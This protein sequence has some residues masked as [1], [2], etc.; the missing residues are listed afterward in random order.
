[1][2][3][4]VFI[5]TILT[6]YSCK[7]VSQTSNLDSILNEYDRKYRI[8]LNESDYTLIKKLIV[9]TEQNCVNF[10]TEITSKKYSNSFIAEFT[11]SMVSNT[12]CLKEVMDNID[13]YSAHG[14]EVMSSENYPVYF[15]IFSSEENIKE[16]GEFLHTSK[17]LDDCLLLEDATYNKKKFLGQLLFKDSAFKTTIKAPSMN[18][19]KQENLKKIRKEKS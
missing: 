11:K 3:K 4:L 1:M 7:S 13:F 12:S 15:G 17:Y 5:L 14:D 2:K 19:C 8:V 10:S 6:I 9:S 18:D 16:M